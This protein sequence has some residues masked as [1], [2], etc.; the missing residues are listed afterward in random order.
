MLGGA[1][2]GDV[3]LLVPADPIPILHHTHN[4]AV[5][6]QHVQLVHVLLSSALA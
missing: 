5:V 4:Q 6:V 1:K 2:P 3:A